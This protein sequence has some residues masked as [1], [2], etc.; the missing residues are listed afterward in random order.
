MVPVTVDGEAVKLATITY[1]PVGA[2]PFPTMIFHHGS[3]GGG[4][5]PSLFAQP[6]D[7]KAL[8]EWFIARG[9]AVVLPSRR[10][11]GGSEGLYDEGFADDRTQGYTCEEARL[12]SGAERALRDIDAVTP[13]ILALP[14]VD[15]SRFAIGGQSRGGIL[16]IAWAGRHPDGPRAVI[17]FVGGWR[18]T[19]CATASS[20]NQKLF[21]RDAVYGPSSLWLYGEHDPFYPLAHS[22]ANFAAFETAGGRGTFHEYPP[23]PGFNG[24]QII[25]VPFLWSAT[26][27]SYLA[28]QGLPAKTAP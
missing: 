27:E 3:T 13:A 28:A 23:P 8:A 16:A 5:D 26:L 2:G 21:N 7:P 15:R 6:F 1:K 22:R 9:W 25:S 24:H 19:S 12:L 11:R 14:F 10:G 17:N 4:T 18:R 20:V